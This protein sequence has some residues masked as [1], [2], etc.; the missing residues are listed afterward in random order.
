MCGVVYWVCLVKVQTIHKS[1][2]NGILVLFLSGRLLDRNCVI[3]NDTKNVSK[4][5][6]CTQWSYPNSLVG[7]LLGTY[8]CSV[9]KD[10][11]KYSL[12]FDNVTKDK[13]KHLLQ[14]NLTLCPFFG[15]SYSYANFR[16]IFKIKYVH[17]KY[18][19]KCFVWNLVRKKTH[20]TLNQTSI[21]YH[22]LINNKVFPVLL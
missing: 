5:I 12:N 14:H 13:A 3:Q 16:Y 15:T 17:R 21:R 20:Q 9:Y 7:N 22:I 1:Y 10:V 8:I 2:F 19:V 18:A 4:S 11:E 6:S